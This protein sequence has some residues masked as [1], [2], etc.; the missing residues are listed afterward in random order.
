MTT[1]IVLIYQVLF[2]SIS[3]FETLPAARHQARWLHEVAQAK[4]RFGLPESAPSV[5]KAV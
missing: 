5:E 2:P 1:F 3:T 4:K